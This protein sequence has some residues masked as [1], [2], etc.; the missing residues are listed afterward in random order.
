M[1]RPGFPSYG[2]GI[3]DRT[4]LVC[5]TDFIGY[6]RARRG[7]AT[8][9]LTATADVVRAGRGAATADAAKFSQTHAKTANE[10]QDKDEES[11]HFDSQKPLV[12]TVNK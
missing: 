7:A 9:S 12:V 5:K 4:I 6:F 1:K 2:N 3:I 8:K 10:S 11:S